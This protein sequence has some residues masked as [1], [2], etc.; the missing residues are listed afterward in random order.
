[1]VAKTVTHL[2]QTASA[3][4]KPSRIEGVE[5]LALNADAEERAGTFLFRM[6]A[7]TRYPKHRHPEG[8][9]LLMLKGEATVAEKKMKAGDFLYSPPGS[10]H[11]LVSEAG[12]MC[13]VS[14]P[15]SVEMIGEHSH[16]EFDLAAAEDH[17]DATR[18]TS[19]SGTEADLSTSSPPPSSDIIPSR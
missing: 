8:E 1:M 14:W 4:W 12:C 15:R 19:T 11:E 17:S 16:E 10:I 5:F 7:G 3:A 6:A 9:E 18:A 2:I 13:L